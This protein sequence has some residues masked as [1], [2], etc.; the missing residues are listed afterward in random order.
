[1]A[2]RLWIALLILVIVE[3]STVSYRGH[4]VISVSIPNLQSKHALQEVLRATGDNDVWTHEGNLVIGENHIRI[5]N[6]S[7]R[8]IKRILETEVFIEDVQDLIDSVGLETKNDFAFFDTFR[9]YAE[10]VAELKNLATRFPKLAKLTT[11]I[12]K[13]VE[14]RDIPS[15]SISSKGFTNASIPR[16]LIQG[17]QHS[18]E[19]IAPA[20][21]MYLTTKLLENYGVDPLV[22]VLVDTVEFVIIPLVNPDGYEYSFTNERLWRKN[23]KKNTGGSFGV[24]LNRNWNDHWGGTGSS[25]T[26]T[27]DTYCG[28]APFSEP[29][30]LAVSNYFS[31][32]NLKGNVLGAIDYHAYGQLVL[33]PYGWTTKNSPDESSLKILG[34][35]I[36]YEIKRNSGLTYTS[37]KAS[38]LYVT[39]GSADDWWYQNGAW[40]VFTIE[41]RDTGRYGFVL[42]ASQIVPTGEESWAS[43]KYYVSTVISERT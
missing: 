43:F 17:G 39:T 9:R 15:I 40:G 29:E 34:D 30:A 18:R 4:K 7:E 37:E 42:P 27:S 31:S 13:T 38:Q 12:G 26:P 6:N 32:L 11:S 24:D 41:L 28:T 22:T 19:W 1:V 16:I 35:G 21:V 25:K 14:S 33:R 5:Q 8:F 3:C 23:R 2:M 10:I 36:S 20:T